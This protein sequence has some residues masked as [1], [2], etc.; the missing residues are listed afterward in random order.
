MKTVLF[1]VNTL[2]GTEIK[3]SNIRIKFTRQNHEN[4]LEKT[5]VL[6]ALLGTGKVHPK[7]A[8]ELSGLFS[9][10]DLACQE[11]MQYESEQVNEIVKGVLTDETETVSRTGQSDSSDGSERSATVQGAKG[12]TE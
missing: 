4:I 7:Y 10:P 11:S 3:P 6:A 2:S 12:K 5:Q 8:F 1:I 9:E